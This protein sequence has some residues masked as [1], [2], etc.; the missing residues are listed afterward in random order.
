MAQI[1]TWRVEEKLGINVITARLNAGPVTCPPADPAAGWSVG[2]VAAILRNPKYTGYQVIGRR[3]RGKPVPV[4]Q[5][6]WS[7]APSH[8]AIVD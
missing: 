6:H 4:E 5:W 7:P 3:R 8:P 2:G 1:Y